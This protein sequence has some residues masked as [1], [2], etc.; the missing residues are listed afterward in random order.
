MNNQN[1]LVFIDDPVIEG[2]ILVSATLKNRI[3]SKTRKLE[4]VV[5]P[6]NYEILVLHKDSVSTKF[7][8]VTEEHS[9]SLIDTYFIFNGKYKSPK[10]EPQ[11]VVE[12]TQNLLGF[13]TEVKFIDDLLMPVQLIDRSITNT[14]GIPYPI[15]FENATN[16]A[17]HKSNILNGSITKGSFENLDTIEELD[18]YN[19]YIFTGQ[20]KSP[21]IVNSTGGGGGGD[22]P[23]AGTLKTIPLTGTIYAR[24]SIEVKTDILNLTKYNISSTVQGLDSSLGL[25]TSS[26]I[27]NNGKVVVI[28]TNM[29]NSDVDIDGKSLKVYYK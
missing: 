4:N 9:K 29:S 22:T 3:T 26:F 24:Q 16:L 18:T 8:D 12:N 28:I 6:D 11:G 19:Y 21:L 13:G 15:K 2:N 27:D 14:T 17:L 10:Y 5:L 1:I 25:T 20:C 7:S 23:D